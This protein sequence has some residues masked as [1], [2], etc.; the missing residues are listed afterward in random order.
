MGN[1]KEKQYRLVMEYSLDKFQE[2]VEYMINNGWK[3]QGGAT[4]IENPGKIPSPSTYVFTQSV[5]RTYKKAQ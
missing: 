2:R 4:I 5:Y 3:M 1:L